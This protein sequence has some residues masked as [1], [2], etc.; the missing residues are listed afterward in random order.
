MFWKGK[1]SLLTN[2]QRYIKQSDVSLVDLELPELSKPTS[3][4]VS[5][6]KLTDVD[7]ISKLLNE[8]F[9][10]PSSR[11]KAAVTPEWIRASY[12]RDQ[13]IWIVA[14]DIGGTIRGCVCSFHIE[15]PYPNSLAG[16]GKPNP[17]GLIDWFCVHP[18]WRSK[19]VGS[20]LLETIDLVTYR[21][22]RKALVFLKEGYPLQLPHIPIYTTWL[23]CRKAGN[24]QIKNMRDDT[25]LAIY[26]YQEVE[27]E[28]GIPL[29][30]V[31]GIKNKAEL[32][33]WEDALDSQLPVSWVFVSG[34]SLVD[35]ERGW[36][37]DSLISM[38]SFRWSPGKWLGH[39]PN[40]SII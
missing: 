32:Q 1:V 14:K 29:V 39:T 9:E 10:D 36:K 16:C 31:E 30:R 6:S 23:K 38:Y 7:G 19:G 40:S 20:A 27:R 2:I 24:P 35:Y 33:E 28:T 8:W 37:T 13:A 12:L 15:A 21:I 4:N 17:W 34:S 5:V 25:G 22:G 26:P 18:L 11:S 3:C